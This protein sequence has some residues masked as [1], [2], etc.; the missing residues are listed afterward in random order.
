MEAKISSLNGLHYIGYK[1][2]GEAINSI[3]ELKK[4]SNVLV[5][6]VKKGR[7]Y[8]ILIDDSLYTIL[9]PVKVNWVGGSFYA[10]LV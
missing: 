9:P 6:K 10:I 2:N 3:S 4:C 1:T 7:G 5:E 8:D